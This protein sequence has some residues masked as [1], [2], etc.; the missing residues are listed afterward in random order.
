[1][2]RS[3]VYPLDQKM[4][5]PSR[6]PA[7]QV[8]LYD[9]RSSGDT[10]GDVV[11]DGILDSLTGPLD[12]TDHV[13][14]VDISESA[15]DFVGAGVASSKVTITLVD[16]TPGGAASRWD[17]QLSADDED[18]PARFL[19]R[20]NV[21]RIR[22][23]D[24]DVDLAYWPWTFTGRLVGQAGIDRGRA[25]DAQGR[26]VIT[27]A[28][29]DRSA[30]Y[31]NQ[32][33]TSEEFARGAGY[34]TMGQEIAESVM[35]LDS[36]EIIFAGWGSQTTG[37]QIQFVEQSPLVSLAQLMF[38]DGYLPRFNGEGK[39]TQA[40]GEISHS[41]VR[42]YTN[43]RTIL[44]IARPYS[45]LNPVNSVEVIGLESETTKVVQQRQPLAQVD[46]TTGF[47]TNGEEIYAYWSDD[48]TQ[49]AE[50]IKLDIQKSVNGGLSA[51]GGGEDWQLILAENQV[52]I[53]VGAIIELD[54]G[55]AP[56]VIVFLTAVYVVLA[57]IPDSVVTAVFGGVTI[58][59]G[60]IVQAIAMAAVVYMMTRIGRG[61]YEFVGDPVEWV[62]QE[63]RAIAELEGITSEDLN[64]L[65]V[66]NH[67]VQQQ[68]WADDSARRVLFREQAKGNPRTVTG[69]HD[70]RLE[71]NDIWES[72]DG[73]RFLVETITRR[74]VRNAEE[75]MAIYNVYEV[76]PG[77]EP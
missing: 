66:E 39:L 65:T 77:L 60:R 36:E 76:T 61:Q 14:A 5:Q 68:T 59:I 17:P 19:R 53:S 7:W 37:L 72:P 71:P 69:L 51:L 57:A 31:V 70:I 21:L 40:A 33:R 9:L 8:L 35:G 23:G 15:S 24:A 64:R 1:M 12:V 26:S 13:L 55:Y 42:I 50:N 29:V 67:L 56:Y 6:R 16:D 43:M 47:F 49:L 30:E 28:A 38:V 73:R 54:T 2:A 46:V 20:G 75:I 48:R 3:L 34:L 52:D 22:E 4:L 62:Y 58:P 18:A 11:R 45:E 74:L 44:H 32:V 63:I 41:P 25:G 10:I 27:M